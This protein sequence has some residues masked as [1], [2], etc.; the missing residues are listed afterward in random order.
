[1]AARIFL[2]TKETHCATCDTTIKLNEHITWPRRGDKHFRVH[3][4]CGKGCAEV[5]CLDA[6]VRCVRCST[7]ISEED[8]NVDGYCPT[9]RASGMTNPIYENATKLE[10]HSNGNGALNTVSNSAIDNAFAGLASALAPM[11]EER[12]SAKV[13]ADTVRMIVG[14]AIDQLP[15]AQDVDA[16]LIAAIVANEVSKQTR[17]LRVENATGSV[18]TIENTHENFAELVYY[19]STRDHVYLYGPA[20]SGK[21]TAAKLAADALSLR[22][23]YISLN[24]G[25]VDSKLLGYM[26]ANGV[27]RPTVFRDFY[28]NGGLYCI[29][30]ADNA[31]GNLL[32]TLN[33]ALENGHCAF[34]DGIVARHPDF[35]IVATG[36]TAGKGANR[37]YAD[38]RAFDGAFADRFTFIN[39][40]YDHKLER[41]IALSLNEKAESWL[42][43]VWSVRDYCRTNAPMVLVTPRA[44]FKG[45]RYLKDGL[46]SFKQIV[47]GTIF[48][49]LEQS[50]ID[51][52]LRACPFNE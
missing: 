18:K 39:W 28:E 49:G 21:S 13:D 4:H 11:I 42:A 19:A 14:E 44:T 22:F 23:G 1:M 33:S 2:A 20:G 37:Q 17:T 46:L 35:V 12:I 27:Y 47:N 7:V 51:A 30:E 40:D 41:T 10:T 45:A 43:F 31:T 6:C 16:S 50:Q 24:V 8:Q 15:K 32:T 48:K 26:D 36:N 3:V 9:C 29:D 34:P 25:T 38:R 5:G 52:I